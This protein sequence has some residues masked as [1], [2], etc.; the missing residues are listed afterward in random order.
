MTAYAQDTRQP[1]VK[2]LGTA[3]RLVV[4]GTVSS[5]LLLGGFA[6]AFLTLT[7][8]V[9]GNGLLLTS[10]GLFLVG[11]AAGLVV[12]AVF[13]LVGRDRDVTAGEACGQIGMGMLCAV[14][15]LA[16]GALLAGWIAMVGM[17]AYLGTAGPMIGSATAA[18]LAALVMI[19][20]ALF[21]L[22]AAGN[23]VQRVRR[24]A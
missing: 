11:A 8:R 4:G 3:G 1:A 16:V 14:P 7:E 24:T 23:M 19:V 9:N 22:E 21:T 18:V 13:A 5:G 17:A 6:V 12:S 20:T 10:M 2:R 15:G